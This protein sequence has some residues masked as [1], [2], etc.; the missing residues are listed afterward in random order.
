MIAKT[1]IEKYGADPDEC[2][3]SDL[4]FTEVTLHVYSKDVLS[5][6]VVKERSAWQFVS[7]TVPEREI[8]RCGWRTY[9]DPVHTDESTT[10]PIVAAFSSKQY[11][12][13]NF[14]RH[15]KAKY[16]PLF[17]RASLPEICQLESVPLVYEFIHS[18]VEETRL[19]Y[20]S[21]FEVVV[22]LGSIEL[23]EYFL[24]HVEEDT[25]TLASALIHACE[26]GSEHM[27][28]RLLQH[29]RHLVKAIQHDSSET[30]HNPLCI[31]IRNYDVAMTEM[32]HKCGAQLFN[33]AQPDEEVPL[34]T[35]CQASLREL[36]SRQ[37]EFSD[38]LPELLPEHISQS[39]LNLWPQSCL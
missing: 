3:A 18:G 16:Q 6:S 32:L 14:F 1:L 36:C 17:K 9:T 30:C 38:I 23:M 20:Q 13:V 21:A 35:L 11:D 27:V 7:D 31:A 26:V 2:K 12:L 39:S 24:N 19:N 8:V 5:F 37:D 10:P 34:H 22:N 25:K 4:Q 29:D 28:R 33:D 15:Q